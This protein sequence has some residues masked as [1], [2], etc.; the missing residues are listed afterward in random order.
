MKIAILMLTYNA[1]R[2]VIKTLRTLRMTRDVDFELIC[3][4]NASRWKTRLVVMIAYWLG[5][6][7]RLCLSKKNTL[8]AGGNNLA[9]K[10]VSNDVT[11]FLLLNSDIEIRRHDWLSTLVQ[12]HCPGLTSFGVVEGSPVDRLDGYCLLIDREIYEKYRLDEEFQWYWAVTRLQ[13]CA[14]EDGYSV[15]GFAE[16]EQYLHHFGGKSGPGFIGAKGMDTESQRVIDW[17]AGRRI[18]L[19]DSKVL[20]VGTTMQEFANERS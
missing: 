12:N 16:H 3:V 7:D 2:Y 6:I 9:S 14:L 5:W 18:S 15:Q 4:D 10:L 20:E 19:L 8:F 1:P 11:H 17:F 13:A